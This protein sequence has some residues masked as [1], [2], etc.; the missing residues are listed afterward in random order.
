MVGAMRIPLGFMLLAT[1]FALV[2]QD[3]PILNENIGIVDFEPLDYPRVA[4]LARVSGVVVVRVKVDSDGKAVSVAAISGPKLLIDDTLSNARKWHFQPKG[5]R[6][7][8]IVYDFKLEGICKGPCSSSFTF[9][10]PNLATITA[11]VR[12]IDH[13]GGN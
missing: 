2:A 13:G 11:G 7:V 12:L 9:S 3:Q 5:S 8:V 1:A 6:D 4:G 10:P